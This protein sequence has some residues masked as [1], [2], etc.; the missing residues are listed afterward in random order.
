M[1]TTGAEMCRS[2]PAAVR[3]GAATRTAVM[4][5]ANQ[6]P[7]PASASA[8]ASASAAAAAAAAASGPAAT[9]VARRYDAGG[10]P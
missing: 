8:S 10:S 6:A 4:R 2:S 3:A 7:A 1:A 9:V 5:E